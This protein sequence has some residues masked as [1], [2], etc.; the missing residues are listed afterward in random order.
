MKRNILCLLLSFLF[1]HL[2]AEVIKLSPELAVS[3]GVKFNE[4]IRIEQ[5]RTQ[6]VPMELAHIYLD[7]LPDLTLDAGGLKYDTDPLLFFKMNF[8]VSLSIRAFTISSISEILADYRNGKIRIEALRKEIETNILKSYFDLLFLSEQ[9]KLMQQYTNAVQNRVQRIKR[10]FEQGVVPKIDFIKSE[11]SYHLSRIELERMKLKYENALLEFKALIG[12][13]E[14]TQLD[15]TVDFETMESGKI[16]EQKEA[17]KEGLA[18]NYELRLISDT[19]QRLKVRKS[20]FFSELI[21]FFQLEYQHERTFF[22]ENIFENENH[23]YLSISLPVKEWL[24]FSKSQMNAIRTENQIQ[25]KNIYFRKR[26]R[27]IQTQISVLMNTVEKNRKNA[28]LLC[29]DAVIAEEIFHLS[30]KLY[31][32]GEKNLL[33]VESYHRDF[34][35]TK[36]NYLNTIYNYR[37]GIITLKHILNKEI[38]EEEKTEPGK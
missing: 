1:F 17:L 23:L 31:E 10:M 24:P 22:G 18:N 2:S 19:I 38:F 30:S 25:Q 29:Q 21:P 26:E 12:V 20:R 34:I 8:N 37:I 11:H 15:F 35:D 13:D 33:E 5:I 27:E 6:Q 4:E 9:K 16:L 32:V 14:E 3:L 36:L 28:V 7:L